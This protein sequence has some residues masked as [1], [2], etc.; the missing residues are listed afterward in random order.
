MT[1]ELSAL[2]AFQTMAT[3]GVYLLLIM[4]VNLESIFS[5]PQV[6]K[7]FSCEANVTSI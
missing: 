1:K 6:N 5:V 2:I 4:T 3:T 7:S